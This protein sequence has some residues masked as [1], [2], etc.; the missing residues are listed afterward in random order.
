MTTK[1]TLR[2]AEKLLAFFGGHDAE[3]TIAVESPGLSP[4]LYAWL[5]EC[6]EEGSQYLGPTEVDDEL[7]DKGRAPTPAAVQPGPVTQAWVH[8]IPMMQQSVLLAAI[9]G[10][11][12][13]PK[14]GGGAKMLLRWYR[15]CVL[16]SAMDGKVLANPIDENGGSFTG[17][18]LNGHDELEHWTDRMQLHVN[19]YMRQVDMLPHHYQMHFMHA[20]EIVGY[21]HPNHEI[22]HF[23]HRVYLRLVLD[24]HLWPETEAQLDDRLG[25]TRSGWLKRADPATME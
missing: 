23:W 24:F 10:P 7:A 16:L 12:G 6:P 5:S 15:R 11:D 13:Q 21:K 4:G 14:Y 9:R 22:R 2:Q 3:V 8:A 20:A 18:S 1:I 17:P 19:D 25:D